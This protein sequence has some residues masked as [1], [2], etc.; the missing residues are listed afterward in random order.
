MFRLENYTSTLLERI[1][2]FYANRLLYVGLQGSYLR[3][4]ATEDSDIDIMVVIESITVE[5]LEHYKKILIGI[6]NYEKSCGFICGKEDLINWNTLE[7]C[8]L[9]HTTKNL[10]GQLSDFIPLYTK[11]N[12]KDFIKLSVGNLYHEL[13]HRYIHS[14]YEK[15]IMKLP[16]TCKSIFFIMQNLYYYRYSIF[17][18][19]KDELLK[20]LTGTDNEVL[21]LAI[22]LQEKNL[23]DFVYT[24]NLLFSWCQLTL[25]SL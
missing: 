11:S 19:S 1:I 2:D 20:A 22:L 8:H 23:Y 7:I 14:D 21:N 13:C 25:K 9:L 5:D 4:D 17:I 12:I 10:Y 15:N 3:N 6:G 16:N 24:F 18:N